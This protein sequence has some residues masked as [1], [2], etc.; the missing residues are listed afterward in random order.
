MEHVCNY[1]AHDVICLMLYAVPK[2]TVEEDCTDE[3]LASQIE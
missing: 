2:R 1:L 3:V